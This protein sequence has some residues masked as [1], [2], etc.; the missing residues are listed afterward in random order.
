[1]PDVVLEVVARD[2]EAAKLIMSWRNDPGT[3]A[4]FYHR[5]PKVW[6]DFWSEFR[7]TYFDGPFGL[8]PLFACIDGKRV[9][10]LKFGKADNPALPEN[11]CDISINVSPTDRGRGLAAPILMGAQKHVAGMG[12]SGILAEVRRENVASAKSFLRAGF[13]ELD[14]EEKTILDTGET[15]SIRRF[16]WAS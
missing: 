4:M 14:P 3:L 6:P 2:E 10:F 8:M 15:A 7:D 11:T 1:M 9:A 13:Q 5:D 16:Y 12:V